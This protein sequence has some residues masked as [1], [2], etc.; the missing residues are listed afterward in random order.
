MGN[1]RRDLPLN[2]VRLPIQ[3]AD[4]T[5]GA[6]YSETGLAALHFPGGPV[7]AETVS[8]PV[9]PAHTWHL[10]TE[11]AVHAILAGK[12]PGQ[13]PPLDLAEHSEFQRSVWEEMRKLRSGQTASYGDL[14]N[15][16]G[17]PGGARAIGNACG[18]NPIP[19]LIPCHRILASGG[20]LGGFSGGLA[21]KRKLLQREGIT[22]TERAIRQADFEQFLLLKI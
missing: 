17:I 9:H 20:R 7:T 2:N 15:R 4:G 21:W 8:T 5:F 12:N 6:V 22:T 1:H 19:L 14:A 11:R 13:F 3:T 16:L 18:A 10:L